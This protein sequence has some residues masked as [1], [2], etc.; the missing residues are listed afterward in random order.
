[1]MGE[2]GS[3]ENVIMRS[4]RLL[5][6]AGALA[7]V[8]A[9]TPAQAAEYIFSIVGADNYS[10]SIETD[11]APSINA[12]GFALSGVPVTPSLSGTAT[13]AFYSSAL[14][15]GLEL[16]D[17]TFNSSFYVA[18]SEQ[19]YTFD[20]TKLAFDIGQHF[21]DG[22]NYGY[23]LSTLTITAAPEPAAWALMIA[24]FGAI[25]MALRRQRV[26]VRYA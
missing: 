16:V 15:G 2:A 4:I 9:A 26:S 20:G 19:L 1:M 21:L 3:L 12:N 8:T 10:F 22:T 7:L 25:G 11:P 5:S 13:V 18:D 6:G 14:G 23:G 17:P 24:G